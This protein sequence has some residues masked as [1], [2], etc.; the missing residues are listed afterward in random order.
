M[1][2]DMENPG[3]SAVEAIPEL[4]RAHRMIRELEQE[5]AETNRGLISLTTELEHKNEALQAMT[6]QLWQAAKLATIGEL[7][8]GIAHEINN[9]LATVT[10]RTESLL[11]ETSPDSPQ[12]R[13]LEVIEQE[14]ERM[15]NLVGNLL[16]F[17][18]GRGR[19]ISTIDV[20]EETEKTLELMQ[21]HLRNRSIIVKR[22]F[23]RNVQMIQADRQQLRQVVLNLI[24]NACDA[25]PNGGTLT[26]KIQDAGM[27]PPGVLITISDTGTGIAPEDLSKIFEPFFTTKAE[28][29]G[30]GLGLPICRR[31]A[32]EHHGR[33]DIKS[34]PGKGTTVRVVMPS[35]NNENGLFLRQTEGV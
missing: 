34:Q 9:P 5:L 4:E 32:Q 3:E 20:R 21:S 6:H 31:I 30:T 26:V 19:Q 2:M 24:T 28:G 17:S 11:A 33:L 7:T 25:M 18:R 16:Q 10:L 8:A 13:S 35:V 22:E 12:R 15:T 14:V 1:K 27:N 23:D 29:K